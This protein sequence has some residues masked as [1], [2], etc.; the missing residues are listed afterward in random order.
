MKKSYI[1]LLGISLTILFFTTLVSAQINVRISD[2]RC[3]SSVAVGQSFACT[4][5]IQN[6]GESDV[7]I[8]TLVLYPDSSGWTE[9]HAYVLPLGETIPSGSEKEVTFYG[10]R[11]SLPGVHGFSRIMLDELSDSYVAD[12]AISINAVSAAIDVSSAS[13]VSPGESFR[14]Y[15]EVMA[16]GNVNMQISFSSGCS[17]VGKASKSLRMN[18]GQTYVTSW[19]LTQSSSGCSYTITAK[20]RSIDGLATYTASVSKTVAT[21]TAAV[22]EERAMEGGAA[23]EK[24]E[25]KRRVW[26]MR[27]WNILFSWLRSYWWLLTL[28]IIVLVVVGSILLKRYKRSARYFLRMRSRGRR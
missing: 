13:S 10:L 4:A 1:S 24:P 15:A 17:Y 7:Y 5:R 20:A 26:R 14:V 25:L 16:G 11:A 28:I 6:F 2:F 9:K 27:K 12:K 19:I 8:N 3:P 18:D 22:E 23:E 21:P